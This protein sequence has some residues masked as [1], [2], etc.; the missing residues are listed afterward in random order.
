MLALF[1]DWANSVGVRHKASSAYHTQTD[2]AS[3]RK[4]K[5]I[6]PMFAAK[7][8]EDGSIWVQGAPSVQI[9]VNTAISEPR[10]KSPEHILLSFDTKLG[11]T[12][13]PIPIAIFSNLL[14][15]HST[16]T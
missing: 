2:G 9:E 5:S 4:N 6:I 11:S 12:P 1:Q 7:K 13:L 14:E 16:H 10:G 3:E 8:L 15:C